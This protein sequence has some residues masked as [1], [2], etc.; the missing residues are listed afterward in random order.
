MKHDSPEYL[1]LGNSFFRARNKQ[2]YEVAN[3]RLAI[4]F[5]CQGH[6]MQSFLGI[7]SLHVRFVAGAHIS[8]DITHMR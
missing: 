2:G 8:P 3:P 7:Q 4:A 6:T 5:T 1:D